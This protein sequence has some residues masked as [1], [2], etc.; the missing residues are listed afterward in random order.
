MCF[1]RTDVSLIHSRIRDVGLVVAAVVYPDDAKT[2]AAAVAVVAFS[3]DDANI[4]VQSER[5]RKDVLDIA[6]TQRMTMLDGS[7]LDIPSGG[8]DVV[9]VSDAIAMQRSPYKSADVVFL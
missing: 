8:L 2:A 6:M 4:V 7:L 5:Y 9:A 3:L 1:Q